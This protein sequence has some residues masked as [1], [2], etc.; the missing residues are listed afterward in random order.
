M[1]LQECGLKLNSAQRELRPH[2]TREFPCA[3]YGAEYED[4]AEDAVPWHWHE[5]LELVYV[6]TGRLMLQIPGE[7]FHLGPGE[8]F[9]VN[10][11]ILHAAVA[12]PTCKAFS[13]VFSPLLIT[14]S[15]ESAFAIKYLTPLTRC[16]AFDGH[17]WKSE[18][19]FGER[20]MAAFSA[21]SAD[22]A[23][24]EFDVRENLSAICRLLYLAYERDLGDAPPQPDGDSARVR[25]MLE[26]IHRHFGEELTLAQIARAADI[27]ERECLRCF[28]RVM[29]LSPVQYLLKYRVTQA[30]ALL[31]R[32]HSGSI[33]DLAGQCGFDSPSHFSQT[34]K[35][36]YRCTPR[37][38]RSRQMKNRAQP[39]G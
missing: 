33:S 26:H 11:N 22:A 36:F 25:K 30:A 5:E 4:S 15:E 18:S 32:E 14:G 21:L 38:Y 31:E 6:E 17:F 29:Q 28:R 34:F 12:E 37:E 7:T 16:T 9:S 1:A 24:Y 13:L 23:G 8:G 27:G 20:F 39:T 2:G 35:R 10:S 19:P 3:G